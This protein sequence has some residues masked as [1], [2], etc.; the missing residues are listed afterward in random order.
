MQTVH[1]SH[2]R[3]RVTEQ[4]YKRVGILTWC[5]G[6]ASEKT[7]VR[8]LFDRYSERRVCGYDRRSVSLRHLFSSSSLFEW[9]RPGCIHFACLFPKGTHQGKEAHDKEDGQTGEEGCP[10]CSR[11][12]DGDAIAAL[13]NQ[14]DHRTSALKQPRR[15]NCEP[16]SRSKA[17]RLC[18]SS[19]LS[20]GRTSLEAEE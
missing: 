6:V 18:S 1:G 20:N 16:A 13:S 5:E 15:S 4:D 9:K 17:V 14:G 2:H 19:A 3:G 11:I 12:V 10:F 8:N 7:T